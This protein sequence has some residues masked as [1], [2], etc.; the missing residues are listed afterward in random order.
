M[1]K[2]SSVTGIFIDDESEPV[3]SKYF[4]TYLEQI[5]DKK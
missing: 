5:I 1:G 4:P 2:H 3:K